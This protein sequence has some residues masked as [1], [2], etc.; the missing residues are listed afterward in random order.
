MTAKEK[1]SPVLHNPKLL[2]IHVLSFVAVSHG[3]HAVVQ[4]LAA[5]LLLIIDS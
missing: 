2:S 1:Q 4:L 5:A 3:Q